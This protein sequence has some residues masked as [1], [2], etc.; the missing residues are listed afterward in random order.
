[1]GDTTKIEW[2]DK[3]FNGW[4]GCT[5]VS[6]ACDHCYAEELAKRYGWAEWGVGKPRHRTSP[7]NW[8]KP[9]AWN[10]KA[11]REGRRYR[12]FANSLS[13]VFDAEVSDEWR[14]DLMALIEATPNLD[15]LLLTKRP[16]VAR[17][18]FERC[19]SVPANVWMG[20]TVENQAMAEAR[21][22]ELLQIPARGHFL[23][24]EPLLG[25]VDL[26]HVA[27][28]APDEHSVFRTIDALTGKRGHGSKCGYTETIDHPG[29]HVGWVI[30]GGES[31][32]D[33]RPM[34]PDWARSLRDQCQAAGV[35]F[36]YKQT[37]EWVHADTLSS[38]TQEHF[39][40]LGR[41]AG[42]FVRVGKKAAGRLLDGREWSE[43]PA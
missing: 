40:A 19:G 36:F 39:D 41:T 2:A 7:E 30:V 9:L 31:G 11:E 34:H 42:E 24:M 8:R 5:K 23:S 18:Y 16:K 29:R 4:I 15:W 21:I 14:A 13:D 10:R 20:T 35:P 12:V 1:M 33:A 26:A 38:E 22:P 3:T 32:A 37:G 25:S 43:F 17:D 28:T 27:V 6:K